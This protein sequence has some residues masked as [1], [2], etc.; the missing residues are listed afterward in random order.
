MKERLNN[1]RLELASAREELSD[2]Q[3]LN[4]YEA[5][6]NDLLIDILELQEE[7]RDRIENII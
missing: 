6:A 4:L 2:M 3:C 7:V 5:I 1:I